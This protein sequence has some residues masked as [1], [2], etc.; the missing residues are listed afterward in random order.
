MTEDEIIIAQ[1]REGDQD[2]FS[3][4]MKKYKSLIFSYVRRKV[5]NDDDADDI[6]QEVFVKV[7]KALPNW[8]PRASFQTWLYT[9]A[10]NRCIDY[11]RAK[12]RRQFHSLDDDEEYMPVPPA[13]DIYSDPEKMAE[14][15]ELG[16]IISEAI[17]QLSP[18]QKEVFILHHYQGLQI[19][20]IAAALGMADGS[21][22]VHHHRAMKKLKNILAPLREKGQI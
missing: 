13:T 22:K 20:E 2:A 15:N 12:A 19:K 21:V 5:G 3:N 18:K 4:L 11:H 14:E 10:R 1:F 6:T 8:Q 17:K 9:I 7:Y 16:R